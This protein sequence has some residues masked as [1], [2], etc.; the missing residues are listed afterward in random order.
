M[1]FRSTHTLS[2]AR[3]LSL[4]AGS[5][6]YFA[7]MHHYLGEQ[8][9]IT[10]HSFTD[11]V[12]VIGRLRFSPT[13]HQF[14]GEPRVWEYLPKAYIGFLKQPA[15]SDYR[16]FLI[17]PVL[18]QAE[19]VT[20]DWYDNSYDKDYQGLTG[21]VEVPG[22]DKLI[23]SV[24]RDSHPVLYDLSQRKVVKKLSLARRA[25]NPT[26]RFRK[27]PC[28]LWADDYD[29]LLRLDISNWKVTDKIVIQGARAGSQQFMGAYAFSLDESLCAVARPF[30]GD[31]VA[32]NTKRFRITHTCNLGH[33]PLT[34]ALLSD[35]TVYARDWKT[36]RLLKG[37]L[38]KKKWFR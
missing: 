6:D 19:V 18:T 8:L 38:T 37:Q 28:E 32:V 23:I 2:D 3:Y 29:T 15:L 7:V 33:Q 31:V 9:V 4:C 35:G 36:G 24:Q 25:G 17:E 5:D 14:E 11:P 12:Q 13:G 1:L 30:S 20:L 22:Q 21:V 10:A 26:L 27:H 34:V 16:L